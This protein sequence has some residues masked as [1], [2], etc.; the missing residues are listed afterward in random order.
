MTYDVGTRVRLSSRGKNVFRDRYDNPH[1]LTGVIIESDRKTSHGSSLI[2][3][4][5]V[6]WSSKSI[7]SYDYIHLEPLVDL[8]SKSL[9][10]YL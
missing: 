9:E 3:D 1:D 4:C 10:D 2:M 7:N 6:K 5:V 8:S